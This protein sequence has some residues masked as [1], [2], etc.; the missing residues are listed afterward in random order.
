MDKTLK[1][2]TNAFDK[3]RWIN[4]SEFCNRKTHPFTTH[5]RRYKRGKNSCN[6]CGAKIGKIKCTMKSNQQ[7]LVDNVFQSPTLLEMLDKRGVNK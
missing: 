1:I 7:M 6:Q 5:Y 2:F 3:K 4:E